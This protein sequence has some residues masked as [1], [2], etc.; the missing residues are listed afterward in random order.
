MYVCIC[1]AVRETDIHAAV[2]SGA[3]RKVR[4]LRVQLGVAAD[5]GRC[6]GCARD[7]LKDALQGRAACPPAAECAAA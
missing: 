5:C 2:A 3:C 7:V 6:A 1:R 4:D